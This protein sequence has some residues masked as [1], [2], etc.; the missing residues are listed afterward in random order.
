MALHATQPEAGVKNIKRNPPAAPGDSSL[1]DPAH[2]QIVVLLVRGQRHGSKSRR[3]IKAE[4]LTDD[5]NLLRV[6]QRGGLARE[7]EGGTQPTYQIIAVNAPV[8][9][10]GAGEAKL[11]SLGRAASTWTLSPAGIV[12]AASV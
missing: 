8:L 12:R 6:G 2:L 4:V 10:V 11:A 5:G 3:Q 9:R 7:G 1:F